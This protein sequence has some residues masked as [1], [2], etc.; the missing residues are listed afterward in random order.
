MLDGGAQSLSQE[1]L[2]SHMASH[3]LLWVESEGGAHL[4]HATSLA[5]YAPLLALVAL[6]ANA[7]ARFF[8]DGL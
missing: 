2:L 1:F 3:E 8:D 4:V 7:L 6:L 5:V